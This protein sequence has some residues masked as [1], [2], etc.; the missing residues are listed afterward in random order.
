M[1]IFYT[2]HQPLVAAQD[3]PDAHITKMP[4][5]SV[6]MLVSAMN[7]HDVEHNVLTKR[8]TVHRGGYKNH[9]CTVWAGDTRSNFSWL[10]SHGLGLCEEFVHRY[11]HPHFAETQLAEILKHTYLIPEGL[12]TT[13]HLAMDDVC[14]VD[15]NPVESYRNCI[16]HKT[17]L[18]PDSFKWVKDPGRLPQWLMQRI[19]GTIRVPFDVPYL[20][21]T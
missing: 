15:N 3:L 11:G 21:A 2:N 19:A 6:Q 5:E 7:R 1:N 9:P 14:K 12:L 4:V 8:G 16:F 18:K 10:L 20:S 17:I 13:P